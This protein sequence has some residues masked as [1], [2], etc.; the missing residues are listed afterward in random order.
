MAASAQNLTDF[1]IIFRSHQ[2]C[3][4]RPRCLPERVEAIKSDLE[5][6]LGY[7]DV[8]GNIILKRIKETWLNMVCEGAE[9]IQ[10]T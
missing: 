4:I 3:S 9:R 8:N 2:R 1:A 6:H 7:K 10:L 5:G